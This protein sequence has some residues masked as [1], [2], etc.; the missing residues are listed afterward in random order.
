MS[1]GLMIK[2]GICGFLCSSKRPGAIRQ[3]LRKKSDLAPISNRQ[4][5]FLLKFPAKMSHICISLGRKPGNSPAALLTAM[6]NSLLKKA[7]TRVWI[8]LVKSTT[9]RQNA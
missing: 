1:Q 2:G 3:R 7:S 5:V 8:M 4:V 6:C 9:R